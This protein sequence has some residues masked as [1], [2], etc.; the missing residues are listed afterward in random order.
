MFCNVALLQG[1]GHSTE[2]YPKGLS[3]SANGRT[4]V[5]IKVE[6]AGSMC[7]DVR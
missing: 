4:E 7:V 5:V 1:P 2:K 3:G 6:T